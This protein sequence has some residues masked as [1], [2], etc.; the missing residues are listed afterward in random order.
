MQNN[1]NYLFSQNWNKFAFFEAS[2][3]EGLSIDPGFCTLTIKYQ[4]EKYV[5]CIGERSSSRSRKHAMTF[6]IEV[7]DS[8]CSAKTG[9][10]PAGDD[11]CRG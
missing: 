2:F 11:R 9:W 1:E 10:F 6:Y 5:L 7:S 8:G 4:S 3:I